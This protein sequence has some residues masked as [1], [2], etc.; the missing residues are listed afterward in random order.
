M[1]LKKEIIE[2]YI[3][4]K[5]RGDVMRIARAIT[6]R[7]NTCTQRN[8]EVLS[9]VNQLVSAFIRDSRP[10]IAYQD[11]ILEEL[12]KITKEREQV[13]NHLKQLAAA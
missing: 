4:H 3:P 5:R 6:G 11:A 13:A 9:Q 10:A 12:V 7:D 1:Q 2:K 8:D